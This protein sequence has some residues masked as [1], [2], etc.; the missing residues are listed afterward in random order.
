MVGGSGLS[1][2]ALSTLVAS[3][4]SESEA[5]CRQIDPFIHP[6]VVV[7]QLAEYV[8]CIWISISRSVTPL[9]PSQLYVASTY[10]R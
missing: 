6:V 1:E 8:A 5:T 2:C 10:L 9:K 4:N 7:K 3:Q